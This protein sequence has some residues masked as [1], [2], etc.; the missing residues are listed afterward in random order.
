M[1]GIS[2]KKV[3]YVTNELP[4][5]EIAERAV[6][7]ISGTNLSDIMEDAAS[8]YTAHLDRLLKPVYKNNL[9]ITEYNKK[10]SP[11]ELESN[12][13]KWTALTGWKPDVIVLDYMERMKPSEEGYSPDKSWLWLGAIARELVWMAKR[14]N[15]VI[16]TAAQTNRSGLG[17]EVVTMDMSQ[18]SIQHL[19]EASAVVTMIQRDCPGKPDKKV[20]GFRAQKMRHS[21]RDN[22]VVWLEAD[23]KKMTITDHVV[24]MPDVNREEEEEEEAAPQKKK[25][26]SG[27][28]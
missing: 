21:R 22:N 15:I 13:N 3:W 2:G 20:L 9:L 7:K 10:I 27:T 26:R 12:I 1:S 16:W 18:G 8:G 17:A 19:Q 14:M 6:A 11:A 23:L 28:R 24:E 4:I 5:E 25:K